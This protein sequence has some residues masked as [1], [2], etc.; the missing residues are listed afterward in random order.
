MCF[1]VKIRGLREPY[2]HATGFFRSIDLEDAAPRI[3]STKLTNSGK[4][5][6]QQIIA[7]LKNSL[8]L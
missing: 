3:S 2:L 5:F 7:I 1:P 4:N 8:Q 6:Q